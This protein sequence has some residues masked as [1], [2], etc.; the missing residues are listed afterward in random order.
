[1]SSILKDVIGFLKNF[2]HIDLLLYMAILVL[3]I[4]V[5]SLIYIIRI[6]DQEEPEETE[7]V[8]LKDVVKT[9]ENNEPSTIDLTNYENEQEEK[10]IISYDELLKRKEEKNINYNEEKVI[11]EG[12]RVRQ[13]SLD[14]IKNHSKNINSKYQ[15][16]EEFLAYL[17]ELSSIK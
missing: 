2:S 17:K 10:A 14:K 6:S 11:D 5:V 13:I 9:I 7:D 8:N 1:M 4:L 15:K 16:E 12:V 3:I